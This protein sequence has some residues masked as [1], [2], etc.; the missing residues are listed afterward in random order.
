MPRDR[1]VD[2]VS[3]TAAQRN[4]GDELI[5]SR[6]DDRI[7]PAMLIGD[8]DLVLLWGIGEAIGVGDRSSSSHDLEC[9]RIDHSNLVIS[10]RRRK[11][12]MDF[13]CGG[14]A[15]H[16]FKAVEI[17]EN[18]SL[19]CVEDN[20]LISVH[21]SDV[22]TTA[23]LI[24]GL[25]VEASGWTGHRDTL[26]AQVASTTTGTPTGTVNFNDGT[27][28]LS[29]VTL[30]GGAASYTTAPLSA[31]VHTLYA[32]YSGDPNFASSSTAAGTPV[33]A[34]TLDFTLTLSGGQSETVAAGSLA[35][36]TFA[37]APTSGAYPGW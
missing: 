23:R 1:I 3:G 33:T 36:Y 5:A 37:I 19:R 14:Y 13:G 8:E 6:V 21:V 15:M 26:T 10:G 32:V 35:A 4:I 12:P 20:K 22:E 30:T 11:E 2:G 7:D 27:T 18:L 17:S 34:G 31:G 9:F 29:T 25:I 16:A 24:E 28:L